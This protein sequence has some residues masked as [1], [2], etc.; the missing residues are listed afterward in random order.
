VGEAH[1]EIGI[2][3]LGRM[4]GGIAERLLR[5]H[6]VVA[7]DKNLE[8]VREAK[9]R[10]AVPAFSHGE[11][12]K[13][14]SPPRVVWVMVPSGAPTGELIESLSN[15]LDPGDTIIDGGNSHYKDSLRRAGELAQKGLFF[16]DVGVS[17]GVWGGEN[18]YGLMVGGEKEAVDRLA[19]IF[20]DLA[21]S[22]S[23][24]WGHVG[25][26]G[27][28][29]YVKMVHNGI[30][31]G[32]MQAYAEGFG[33]IYAKKEFHLAPG[34]IARIWRHGTVIRSWLLDLAAGALKE[35]PRLEGVSPKVADSGEGRW[36]VAEATELGVPVPVI[37]AS[38]MQRLGSTEEDEFGNK[39]LSA[40]RNQFGGHSFKSGE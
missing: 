24:G 32:L 37:A 27:A 29:H 35:N 5:G 12:V 33:L 30:E 1:V 39:L 2:A 31:Y 8:A 6:R 26:S 21:P 17:G 3:G 11:L 4:G 38:L 9:A 18:G 20:R 34:E 16:V 25:P 13:S 14:L 36:T 15:L 22:P 10:G 19:P 40:L 28:G 23:T 7:Y